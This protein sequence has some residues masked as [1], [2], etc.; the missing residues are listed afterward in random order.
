MLLNLTFFPHC[1]LIKETIFFYKKDLIVVFFSVF[2]IS[3]Y[4]HTDLLFIIIAFQCLSVLFLTFVKIILLKWKLDILWDLVSI[5]EFFNIFTITCCVLL[6]CVILIIIWCQ[7]ITVCSAN[8]RNVWCNCELCHVVFCNSVEL[9][10]KL[11]NIWGRYICFKYLIH[12]SSTL[13]CMF[14]LLKNT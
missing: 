4:I 11:I 14:C 13:S 2:A 8:C 1:L 9:E 5:N 12:Y 7:I 6:F 3:S 10:I